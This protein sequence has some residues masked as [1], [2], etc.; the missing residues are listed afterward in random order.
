MID[1]TF[2]KDLNFNKT[3][4]HGVPINTEDSSKMME[5]GDLIVSLAAKGNWSQ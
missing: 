1:F 3:R 2:R 4:S 5:S